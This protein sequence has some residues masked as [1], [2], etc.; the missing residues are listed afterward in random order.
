MILADRRLKVRETAETVAMDR[1]HNIIH[2]YLGMN[3]LCG[4]WVIDT[5]PTTFLDETWIHYFTPELKEQ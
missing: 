4:G 2:I 3:K 1:A 5:L